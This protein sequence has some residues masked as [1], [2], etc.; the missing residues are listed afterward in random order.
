MGPP[1]S[2]LVP[3]GHSCQRRL[4]NQ[5]TPRQPDS[6]YTLTTWLRKVLSPPLQQHLFADLHFPPGSLLIQELRDLHLTQSCTLPQEEMKGSIDGEMAVL[7]SSI[8]LACKH[9]ASLVNRAGI[10]NL[11]GLAGEQ[12][13]QG[14]DQKKLDVISNEVFCNCLRQSGRTVTPQPCVPLH[15]LLPRALRW[16]ARSATAIIQTIAC[17]AC[18]VQ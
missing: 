5:R 13:V 1:T 9:I 17:S 3:G 16:S 8:A 18:A 6:L 10:A 7:V 14:E 4:R 15:P 2:S 11:V 12:N